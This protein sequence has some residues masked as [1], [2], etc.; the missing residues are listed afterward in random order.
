MSTEV[1]CIMITTIGALVT[2]AI[3][4]VTSKKVAANEIKKLKLT[5]DREDAKTSSEDIAELTKL[6]YSFTNCQNN[7]F[8]IPAISKTAEMRLNATGDFAAALD[9]LYTALSQCNRIKAEQLISEVIK[10]KNLDSEMPAYKQQK[11]H[12]KKNR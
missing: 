12:S 2:T 3:S 6:V 10:S 8:A 9:E 1:V 4:A 11:H 5:W 7:T